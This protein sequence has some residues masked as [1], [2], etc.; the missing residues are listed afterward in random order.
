MV[1]DDAELQNDPAALSIALSALLTDSSHWEA[2]REL[3]EE[4][5]TCCHPPRWPRT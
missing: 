1:L 5:A 3:R 2:A 4:M